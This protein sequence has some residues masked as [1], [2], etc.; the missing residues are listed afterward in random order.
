MPAALP[1]PDAWH[2]AA[3]LAGV[4]DLPDTERGVLLVA[5]REEWPS[6][7]RQGRGGGREY[8]VSALPEKARQ[9]LARRALAAD[10]PPAATVAAER[11]QRDPA[12]LKDTSRSCMDARA[13]LCAEVDRVHLEY[14]LSQRQAAQALVDQARARDLPEHLARMVPQANARGGRTGSRTL[15]LRS[16]QR[17]LAA[18]AA[19]GDVTALAPAEARARD[20]AP[21]VYPLM[22]LYHRP[23]KPS[24]AACL[25]W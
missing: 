2:T 6:R 4:A 15:S 10:A 20:L 8:P 17:W 5:A 23:Q 19:G 3:E 14:G 22:K 13:A 7:P 12:D 11:G 25:E 16:I 18:R 1:P 24:I 9:A 21:W